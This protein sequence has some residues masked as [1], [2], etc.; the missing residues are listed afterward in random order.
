M[1][2]LPSPT[3]RQR[4]ERFLVLT[5]ELGLKDIEASRLLGFTKSAWSMYR[6]GSSPVPRY[7][8]ASLEMTVDLKQHAL[9]KYKQKLNEIKRNA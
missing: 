2:G 7:A 6:S 4:H 9:R 1:S 3:P 8:I 5:A